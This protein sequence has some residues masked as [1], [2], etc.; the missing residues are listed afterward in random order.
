MR[1]AFLVVAVLA[2]GGLVVLNSRADE[3]PKNDI[4][5]V[6]A[7]AHKGKPALCAKV[8]QGKASKEEKA[9]LLSLYE[10]LAKNE[11][12]KGDKASWKAKTESLVKAAKSIVDEEKGGVAA[13]KKALNCKACHDAHK[14]S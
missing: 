8:Q 11:P 2:V 9:E 1:K 4:K 3:K 12:P 6:M 5:E 14:G 13:Y 10:D 7:K